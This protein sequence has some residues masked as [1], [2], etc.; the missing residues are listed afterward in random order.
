[1]THSRRDV[2]RTSLVAVP[3]LLPAAAAVANQGPDPVLALLAEEQAAWDRFNAAIT[4][5]SEVEGAIWR[6]PKG[7][8][9]REALKGL[10]TTAEQEMSAADDAAMDALLATCSTAPNTAAGFLAVL[11]RVMERDSDHL[12]DPH[13]ELFEGLLESARALFGNASGRA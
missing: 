9:R 11:E 10:K 5:F 8:P 3:A 7:D 4:R 2:L 13:L 6:C 12:G 1:M